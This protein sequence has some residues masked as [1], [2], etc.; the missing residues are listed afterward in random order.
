MQISDGRTQA[1]IK[2]VLSNSFKVFR[3]VRDKVIT[4]DSHILSFRISCSQVN[5]ICV[6]FQASS[7]YFS[8]F[9]RSIQRIFFSIGYLPISTIRFC[10][11]CTNA[12]S[13]IIVSSRQTKAITIRFNYVTA[14]HVVH[15]CSTIIF[16]LIL[17]SKVQTINQAE[18]IIVTVGGYASSTLGHKY[19]GLSP[20]ISTK[21]R[22]HVS[23]SAN[24]ISYTIVATIVD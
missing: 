13:F 4:E 22:Q 9:T 2:L 21:L 23:P 18:E 12:K 6:I 15:F 19:I 11:G 14:F 17:Q 16:T 24:I 3:L 5:V 10:I 8:S 7:P 20:G 1:E